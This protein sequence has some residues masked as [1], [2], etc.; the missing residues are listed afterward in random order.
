MR[1]ICKS[2]GDRLVLDHV[3]LTVRPGERAGIVGENGSG[4]STLLRLAA[5]LET[6]DDGEVT[7][8]A[9][10]GT[11]HLGPSSAP[12]SGSVV[13]DAVDAA[14]AELRALESRM[15]ELEAALSEPEPEHQS[16]PQSEPQSESGSE[17]ESGL[18]EQRLAEYGE[19]LGAYEARGGYEA[20]ARLDKALHGLGLGGLD[21]DR[22]LEGLS[23]GERARLGLACLLAASPGILLLDEPTDHLDDAATRWLE[24]RLRAHPG[25]VVVISH[26]RLFLE[27]V[28]T[29]ILEVEE[30]RVTRYG[31]GYAA[32]LA[33]RA[34]A[35][36]RWEQA[37]ADWCREVE[38][39][40]AFAATTAHRVA[41]GR[42]M[43]D[44]NKMAYDRDAGRVQSSIAGRVRQAQERLR[45][46]RADPV[47]RPP[48][49]L[50][51]AGRFGCGTAAPPAGEG[52]AGGATA[53]DRPLLEP[54]RPQ[55]GPGGVPGEPG[56]PLV[57]LDGVRVGDR[58]VV[59][60]LTVE[61]GQR[62]LVHGPN[63]AGKST[64]LRVLAGDLEPDAGTVRRR[65]RVGYLPQEVAFAVPSRSVAEAFA[66]G[67]AGYPEEHRERL[68]SLGLF[69][70]ETLDVPVGALSTGQR[71]RL[72]LARLLTEEAGLL[73]LD[74]PTNHLSPALAEELEQA[75]DLYGGAVV[76]VSHDRALR[77]RFAGARLAM[78]DGRPAICHLPEGA[79]R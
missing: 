54:G 3:S 62:L 7:V 58:L 55:A 69:R 17:S 38:R 29:S 67:R 12:L 51:F 14:L 50:R 8:V 24:D 61:A 27:R 15:R 42:A 20:D 13:Q 34:A 10:G 46:L 47:P 19:L 72:G 73:L 78:R 44:G 4:K 2:Y 77:R 71:R 22:P 23:G 36:R 45:R 43:K 59:G 25:I 39:V 41:H 75:L 66:E 48:D 68:L 18:V 64:L 37:Y 35:R 49:P 26:D 31:G 6:P 33:G 40:E 56:R 70:P 53:P 65:G 28:A 21:R 57:E 74:E 30:G 9:D 11:G 16:E 52:P 32:F 60:S 1:G 63:G 5:G 76:L 79:R